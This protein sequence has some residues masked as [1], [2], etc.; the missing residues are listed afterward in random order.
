MSG[1]WVPK[2]IMFGNSG[3]KTGWKKKEWTDHVQSEILAF[4]IAGDWKR[5]R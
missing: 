5:Q 1:G 3:E 4:G 2:R